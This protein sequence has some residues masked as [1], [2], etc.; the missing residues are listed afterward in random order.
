M[1]FFKNKSLVTNLKS[2]NQLYKFNFFNKNT[3]FYIPAI[4]VYNTYNTVVVNK[5]PFLIKLVFIKTIRAT[6]PQISY[7]YI[8]PAKR[9][10]RTLKYQQYISKHSSANTPLREVYNSV[11]KI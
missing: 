11:L 6:L 7:Q 10:L 3:E 4:E 9:E 2:K 1:N 5:L 8:R